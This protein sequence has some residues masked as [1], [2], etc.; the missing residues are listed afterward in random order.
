MVTTH[1]DA[2]AVGVV[3]CGCPDIIKSQPIPQDDYDYL[4]KVVLVIV[5]VRRTLFM[6]WTLDCNDIV[7][8]WVM[9]PSEKH[10]CCHVLR[11]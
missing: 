3:I 9:Q 7:L 4:Y 5:Q 6:P 10:I 11:C 1:E 8:R 2:A